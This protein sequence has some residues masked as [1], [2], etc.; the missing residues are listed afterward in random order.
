MSA[1][2]TFLYVGNAETRDLSAFKLDDYP[3]G[4][5]PNWVEIVKL[6]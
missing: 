1:S 2:S 6:P 4:K 3:V 5:N